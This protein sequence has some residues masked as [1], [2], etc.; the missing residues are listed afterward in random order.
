MSRV[1]TISRSPSTDEMVP[2]MR[3][4]FCASTTVA[5]N[6]STPHSNT[7]ETLFITCSPCKLMAAIVK[8]P[9]DLV[10]TG[11]A[12]VIPCGPGEIKKNQVPV[13][14]L[15]YRFHAADKNILRGAP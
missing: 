4:G 14:R 8:R 7:A 2:R 9:L 12:A 15:W 10:N 1:L 5:A 6:A 3:I 11:G 13:A